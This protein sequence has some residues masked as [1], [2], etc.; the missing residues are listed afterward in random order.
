MIK[1]Y[2][3]L[4]KDYYV[5]HTCQPTFD[6]KSKFEAARL[7][8]EQEKF[9]QDSARCEPLTAAVM[10]KCMYWRRQIHWVSELRSGT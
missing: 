8:S 9:M 10:E 4:V 1:G 2:M 5:D 3:R 7:V 6:A